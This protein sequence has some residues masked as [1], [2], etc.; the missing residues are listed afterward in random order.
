MPRVSLPV[1]GTRREVVVPSRSDPSGSHR[2]VWNGVH[3]SCDCK[4][5]YYRGK[6]WAVDEQIAMEEGGWGDDNHVD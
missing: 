4:G 6:C 3:W 1:P 5:F 2:L